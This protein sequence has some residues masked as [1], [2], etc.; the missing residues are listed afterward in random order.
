MHEVVKSIA[1]LRDQSQSAQFLPEVFAVAKSI[2]DAVVHVRV[3]GN[4]TSLFKLFCQVNQLLENLPQS[5]PVVS[6]H[7]SL[8][9]EV[10]Y[11]W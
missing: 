10:E 3:V 6:G 1:R 2:A 5:I 4:L 7:L 8:K 9:L 11:L